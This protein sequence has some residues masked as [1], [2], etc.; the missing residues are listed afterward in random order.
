MHRLNPNPIPQYVVEIARNVVLVATVLLATD[1]I[2][3][4]QVITGSISGIVTDPTGAAIPGA[5]VTVTNEG[6]SVS[7]SATTDGE[8]FYAIEAMPSGEYTVRISKQGFKEAITRGIHLDPGQRRATNVA[9]QVGSVASQVTVDAETVQVDTESSETGG[10]IT[11]KQINN[12]MLNGRNFQ[13][14]AI[15]VPGVSSTTGSD[16][17]GG[18]G[19]NGFL[20]LIVNGSS[21]N[22][23]AYTIDGV[24][25][26]YTGNLENLNVLPIAEGISEFR[27]LTG[28]YSAKYGLAGTGQILVNTKSGSGTFH[29]S[30]WDY[31]RNDAFDARNYFSVENQELRQNIFGYTIGGPV[32]IPKLYNTNRDKNTFFFAAG[33]WQLITNGGVVRG[34]MFPQAMRNGDFSESPTLSGDLTLDAHSQDLLASQGKSNCIEGPTTLNTACFDSV[35]VALMNE[36]WPL[37]NNPSGGFLNFINQGSSTTFQADQQYRIDHSINANN[38]LTG[39]VIYEEVKNSYPNESWQGNPAP[40]IKEALYTTGMNAL[41]RETASLTPNL[42]NTIGVAETY[43]KPRLNPVGGTMPDGITIVQSFPGADMH[44]RIPNINLSG[45]WAPNGV[46]ALPVTASEGLTILSDDVSWVKKRHVLQVGGFYLWEVFRGDSQTK[47]Q[48]SFSFNGSHTGDPAADYL[49]GLNSSYKQVNTDRYQND[50]YQQSEIYVQDDW[51]VTP[52]LAINAGLRWA[53]FSS[54]YFGGDTGNDVTN[55]L[56]STFVPS[57]APVVNLDGT[58]LTNE[59]NVPITSTGAVANLLNGLVYAGKD[60]IP[61]GFFIPV[62]TNFGPRLGFAFDLTGDG[63]TV[64]RGGYGIGYS[65]EASF[66]GV[67]YGTN[68]PYTKSAHVLNSLLSDGTAGTAAA[69]TTQALGTLAWDFRPDQIQSFSLTFER[70]MTAKMIAQIGYVGNLGRRLET[71][72]ADDNFPL[73]V[74]QPSTDG[75][76]PDDQTPSKTY[77]FDP[78]I[79]AGTVSD[80]YTRPYPGY[81]AFTGQSNHGS[82]NYN[83]LQSEL[84]YKSGGSEATVAY[85]YGKVLTT[86]GS[87]TTGTGY[88]IGSSIQNWRDYTAEYGPPDYDFTHD[89]TATWVYDLPFFRNSSKF[90]QTLLGHWS[91]AGMALHQSGFAVSPA[92]STDTNGLATR[93]NQIAPVHLIKKMDQWFD[94]SAFVAPPFGFFGNAGNGTIREPGQTS[95]NV[96][97]YKT[98]PIYDRLGIQFRVEAF[99]VFNHPSFED[100]DT[101]LGDGNYGQVDSAHDPRKMELALKI[102]F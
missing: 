50:Y 85:T 86:I 26:E 2:C 62:K 80:S 57:Q 69:P 29:G 73:P 90:A 99:N 68:P 79:N 92:I 78:C 27:V 87:R 39:R 36:Y 96:S 44:N 23:T 7:R 95:F 82:S 84:I 72:G 17:L 58:L 94:T 10:T 20:T 8:G 53:Y 4:Q 3:A 100:V 12:M 5:A 35:S 60:G 56:A 31:L 14:L 32:I 54:D 97:L 30:G 67:A 37:P 51:K 89:L 45:G 13:T 11:E 47:P 16:A 21:I 74:S 98:F 38:T 42:V 9:L 19:I 18:G 40:T 88:S 46:G 70:Q 22:Y 55:F 93:P 91:F 25:D 66:N 61:K 83:S 81:T 63:K 102:S 71:Q 65:R 77:Q 41:I 49:L 34:A 75:C 15:A 59:D 28:N 43:N 64:L 1:S 24:Y 52:R 48:G 33:Q 6:T 101:I 76:L